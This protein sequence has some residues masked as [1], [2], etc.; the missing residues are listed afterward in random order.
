MLAPKSLLWLADHEGRGAP[1]TVSDV[2]AERMATRDFIVHD[3]AF[4]THDAATGAAQHTVIVPRGTR[5]PT[6]PA[7]WK[8]QLVPTCSLGVEETTFKLVICEVSRGDG[9]RVKKNRVLFN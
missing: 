7:F 2:A 8:R 1:V 9:A 5:F 4:V 6:P 3:Y